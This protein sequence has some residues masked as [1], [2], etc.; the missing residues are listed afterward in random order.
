MPSKQEIINSFDPNGPGVA[1]NLFG[2]PF[3][4]EH[5]EIVILPLPWEITVSYGTGTSAGPQAILK[6]SSQVDL[7]VKDIP[8]AWKLGVSMLP[9]AAELATESKKLRELASMHIARLE[10]GEAFDPSD[11]LLKTMNDASENLNIYVKSTTQ[12]YLKAGKL[13][14]LVGGEH[15]VPL[16]FFR[17]LSETYERFGILQIDAHADLRKA[18]EG[19]TYSH[20]SIMYNALKLPAIG[21]IVQVGVRDYCE[22]ES[23][24]MQ[25]AMGRVVTY[26]DEDIKEKLYGGRTWDALCDEIIGQLPK[27]VYISFDIDG[28]DPKLCPCTGTPVPGGLEFYQAMHLIKKLVE[29]KRK[30][31]GFDLCEVSPGRDDWDANVGARVLYQLCNWCAVSQGKLSKV[32]SK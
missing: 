10:K 7:Y 4:E 23:N 31:I 32:S 14:G 25:R 13:I 21:R 6:A 18:Y 24:V 29:S 12:K 17:A 2:L 9:I 1:G 26:F 5:A 3:T 8:D 11:P 28:L 16:G 22:E 20:A 15:S 27:Y 19:F 30:I